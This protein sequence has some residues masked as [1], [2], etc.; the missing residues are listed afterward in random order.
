MKKIYVLGVFTGRSS[1]GL[2]R[3]A[4]PCGDV[5]GFAVDSLI[6]DKG[7]LKP[8]VIASHFSSGQNWCMHDMGIT[9]D[10]KHNIY[11]EKYPDGYELIWLGCFANEQD[12][13]EVVLEKFTEEFGEETNV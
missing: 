2:I 5:S 1:Y 13:F 12:A 10:W 7:K 3:D 9:S 11:K 4:E 8:N 6:E